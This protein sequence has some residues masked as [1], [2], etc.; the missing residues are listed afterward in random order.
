MSIDALKQEYFDWMC[1]MVGADD[2]HIHLLNRL[3]Q[4]PFSYTIPMDANRESDGFDLRYLFACA[5]DYPHPMVAHIL[6]CSPCS[7][8]EMMV[9]L[10]HRCESQFM[11][12]PEIGDRTSQWFWGMICSLGLDEATD[13]N[14]DEQ[15]VDTVLDRFLNREYERDGKGGLFT[16]KGTTEDLRQV[17]IW[18]QMCWYLNSIL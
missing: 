5:K 8:L 11:S 12:D 10:A 6:D 14:Y 2:S 3:N 9:A 4:V 7:V 1:S 18:Y 15:F 13:D 16:I 17:E